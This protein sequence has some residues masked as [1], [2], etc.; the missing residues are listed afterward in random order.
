[1]KNEFGA[2]LDRNGY[3]PSIL[4]D[5]DFCALCYRKD[6]ALQRHEIFHND[7]G[8]LLRRRS[9]RYGL[10]VSIC[11]ECHRAVHND[12]KAYLRLKGWAQRQAMLV[13]GWTEDD[14]R[15]HFFKSYV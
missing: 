14:F 5:F 6:R 2:V 8:G 15:K 12:P 4:G 1:M 3:A 7:K 13:Y 11:D 9:K 10:W